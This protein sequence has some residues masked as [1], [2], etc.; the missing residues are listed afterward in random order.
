MQNAELPSGTLLKQRYRVEE[1][2]GRGG[3][4]IVYKVYDTREECFAAVKELFP[5]S[6]CG[7]NPGESKI[8]VYSSNAEPVFR[9]FLNYFWEEGHL[10]MSFADECPNLVRVYDCFLENQTCYI[11]ME[12]LAGFEL[13]VYWKRKGRKLPEKEIVHIAG[14]LLNALD[15]IHGKGTIHRDVCLKNSFLTAAGQI[16]LIDF[17]AAC[18]K[19]ET[20]ISII[21]RP[22]YSPPEQYTPQGKLGFWTDLYALGATLYTLAAG[23]KPVP[24]LDRIQKDTLLPPAAY[25]QEVSGRL[26]E[27]IMQALCLDTRGRYQT[28]A[29]FRMALE[30]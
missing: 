14:E 10:L 11:V 1:L 4:A 21:I 17:G 5:L 6:C 7:R 9:D 24:S 25:N 15:Y 29:E 12:I 22:G 28:A 2:I 20:D 18:K 13:D 27:V 19:G 23:R 3:A 16:K 8:F 26:G 30:R